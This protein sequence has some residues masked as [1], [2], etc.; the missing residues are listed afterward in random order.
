MV[1]RVLLFSLL[2]N[3]IP[4]LTF[5]RIA[6]RHCERLASL[7]AIRGGGYRH[8]CGQGDNGMARLIFRIR[9]DRLKE[10]R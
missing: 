3:P 2:G 8:D 4:W 1:T 9:W 10:K 7:V 5:P 6:I